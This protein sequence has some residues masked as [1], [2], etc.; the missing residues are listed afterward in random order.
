MVE[1]AVL[2][3]SWTRSF[4]NWSRIRASVSQ[5]NGSMVVGLSS[6]CVACVR[7]VMTASGRLHVIIYV[8][9]K[10]DVITI[11]SLEGLGQLKNPN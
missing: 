4:G 10:A 9:R 1:T 8:R 2:P 3:L 7:V 11:V 6:C 5:T